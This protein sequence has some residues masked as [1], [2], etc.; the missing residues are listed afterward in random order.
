[1]NLD[2][3][4]RAFSIHLDLKLVVLPDLYS[5]LAKLDEIRDVVYL[6]QVHHTQ[7]EIAGDV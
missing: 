7:R 5:T 6:A 1:M 4:E 3:L 2:A